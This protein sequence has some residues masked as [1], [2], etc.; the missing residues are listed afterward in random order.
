VKRH[1]DTWGNTNVLKYKIED[2]Q[3]KGLTYEEAIIRI[4][5]E[6]GVITD[7]HE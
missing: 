2:Y 6:E 4:A 7:E 1:I 5:E 3:S